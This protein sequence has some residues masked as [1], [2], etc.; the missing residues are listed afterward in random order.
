MFFVTIGIR[1]ERVGIHD[2]FVEDDFVSLGF[3]NSL[4]CLSVHVAFDLVWIVDSDFSRVFS[5][6]KVQLFLSTG[7]ERESTYLAFDFSVFGFVP[8]ILRTC[9]SKF[10]DMISGFEFAGEFSE[11]ISQGWDGLTRSMR[12]DDGICVKV[13]HLFGVD[14]TESLSVE[15][16]SG[17]TRGETGHEDVDVDLNGVCL[18]DVF[19]DHFDH[20][21]VDDAKGLKFLTVVLEELMQS[22]GL[23]DGFH[24]AL[25]ALLTVLAPETVQHHF[26]QGTST[27]ILLD[28]VGLESDTFLGSV[29]VD[30]LTPF[31]FVIAH[32]VGPSAGFL[33]D[34]EKCVDVRGEHVVGSTREV[35][36]FVHVLN[37]V[38]LRASCNS[39]V[40]Q[41][42]TRQRCEG[43]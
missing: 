42:P 39:G 27:G 9:G 12:E 8:I 37:D 18:L 22:G 6:V 20:F 14:S 40:G 41:V 7:V 30:V 31:V 21:V 13:Q 29:I 32:P 5:K 16:E 11:M 26:G 24:F 1:S 23:R 10:D 17:P 35:P 3:F 2:G 34:F 15:F 28:F 36:Y 19:V 43:V 38:A 4:Q 33:F 25:V